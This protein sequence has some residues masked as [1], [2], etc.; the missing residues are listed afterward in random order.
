M[1]KFFSLILF[2]SLVLPVLPAAEDAESTPAEKI[3]AADMRAEKKA[4]AA[5]LK[6]YLDC[7]KRAVAALKKVKDEKS[8]AKAEKLIA[9]LYGLSKKSKDTAMGERAERTRPEYAGLDELLTR[10]EKKIAK[11]NEAIE[12][13][14]ARIDAAGFLTP[15]LEECI[16]KAYE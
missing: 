13:E 6:D 16:E 11:Y 15:E 7:K 2:C 9:E 8:A 14:K 1:K 12:K 4:A 3:S 5:W 10:N